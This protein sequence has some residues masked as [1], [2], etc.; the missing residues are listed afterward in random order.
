MASRPAAFAWK[1]SSCTAFSLTGT[2]SRMACVCVCA[3]HII[4]SFSLTIWLDIQF[5]LQYIF[6]LLLNLHHEGLWSTT[7]F[8]KLSLQNHL[9]ICLIIGKTYMFGL[10]KWSYTAYT[11]ACK[12]FLHWFII[13]HHVDTESRQTHSNALERAARSSKR[14]TPAASLRRPVRPVMRTG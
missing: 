13:K 2:I 5:L 6:Q 10:S 11:N 8:N 12:N 9:R 3:R 4:Y 1:S 14:S 7:L